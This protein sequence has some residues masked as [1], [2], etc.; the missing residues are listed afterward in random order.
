[1]GQSKRFT[2]VESRKS[3]E[4]VPPD[5]GSVSKKT[6]LSKC[7]TSNNGQMALSLPEEILPGILIDANEAVNTGR[8]SEARDLLD[9]Q[10]VEAVCKIAEEHAGHRNT[11]YL[12]LGVI[13]QKV[14]RPAGALIYYLK[15]LER[16]QNALVANEI[17]N[18][19]KQTGHYSEA[20][21]YRTLAM[22]VEPDNIGLWSNRAIDLITL[23]RATEG[24]ELMRRA[25]EKNPS[26]SLHSNILWY[27]QYLPDLDPKSLFEENK[28]WGQ[29]H[30]PSS[31][32]RKFHANDPDPHRRLR[33][34][35]LC[36]DFR[37]HPTAST[38][39]PFL[40]GHDRELVE[41]Y[42]YGNV[43]VPDKVTAH[44][45]R[46]FDHYRHVFGTSDETLVNLIERDKIDI[47]VVIGGR[48]ANNRLIATAYKPA[49]I[50][51]DYGATNT[52]GMEQIDY[53]L[54]DRLLSPPGSEG[55]S[56]EEL[57]YLPGGLYCF[58]PAEDAPAVAPLPA[59]RNGYVTFGSFNACVKSNPYILSIWANVLKANDSSRF[60]MKINGGNNELL[61]E[62]FH[63]LFEQHGVAKERI[64]IRNWTPRLEHLQLY[65]DVDII[66][67]TY[68]FNGA[69]TTL[70]GLWMGVPPIS[71][72]GEHGFI[73][74][75]G[76]SILSRI[77]LEFFAVSTPAE[78]VAK[79]TALATNLPALAKIRA[80]MRQRV[81]CSSLRDARAFARGLED[82]YRR[83]WHR[84]CC[85]QGV[86]VPEEKPDVEAEVCAVDFGTLPDGQ[87]KTTTCTREGT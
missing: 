61:S 29:I 80:S 4:D 44:L 84:W 85:S 21:H 67:D 81:E 62:H 16:E 54:T 24:I 79:A 3:T 28:R 37:L 23:G 12:L 18:I 27:M 26:N 41:I 43:A 47:L 22:E 49:P 76:L 14:G 82:A 40:D 57:A 75:T 68:P 1:M 86:D 20:E 55:L 33:V 30:A 15:I 74:R 66:L 17:A 60:L 34:G 32:A 77:G 2:A 48:V 63:N 36:P 8:T 46:R 39:E 11:I 83:M 78:Y 72:V 19:Y 52:T 38:F 58:K 65:G 70:E 69:M 9:D 87:T 64:D 73:S 31:M 71:L 25:L 56:V 59:L 35:Y 51:V 5:Q 7:L 13:L 42:G 6:L 50:Q 10:N 45:K 53:R